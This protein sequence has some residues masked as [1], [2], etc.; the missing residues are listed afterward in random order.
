M[1]E[2]STVDLPPDWTSNQKSPL[3][4][5]KVVIPLGIGTALSLMGDATLYTVLPTHTAEAGITLAAVG[6]ILSANRFIRLIL[7]GPTGALY[8]RS[9]RRRLFI[10][11]LFVGAISTAIYAAWSGFWP[12]MAGR[13][14]W[15]LAWA[16]IWVGGATIILD[17]TK[18]SNR[19]RWT[20]IY[21]TWFFLGAAAGA[22]LGGLLT[23]WVGYSNALWIGAV[24]TAA[25]ALIAWI[26][27]PETRSA[28]QSIHRDFSNE[29]PNKWYTN[30]ELLGV[31]A[32]QG[33]NR[34]IIAGVVAATLALLVQELLQINNIAIGVAT[35]TGILFGFR[36][37]LSMI[38]APLAGSMSDKSGNRW[39]ITF[40][41]LFLG[42][43][44]MLIL[45]ATSIWII[46]IGISLTAIAGGTVQ[47]LVTTRT[48]DMVDKN[49]RGK[50]IGLLHTAGDLGSALGP[51]T[52]Y[53][54]L[55]WIPLSGVYILCAVIFAV[56]AAFALRMYLQ[57]SKTHRTTA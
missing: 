4:P 55:R 10:P 29:L 38:A 6:I 36:T 26:F 53:A 25:G 52:A 45:V 8:D 39:G 37:I 19:G 31:V 11:A 20:G 32:L 47:A 35:V 3:N 34:F 30:R 50:A 51:L 40:I 5:A 22:F 1:Y 24:L 16:G 43:L 33:I 14:L 28:D 44:G 2:Q 57:R 7:N 42:A 56:G 49:R 13:L 21:Q 54:L 27:L 41:G 9:S 17:V 18:D 12:L 48:G 23:D 46:L 15:G